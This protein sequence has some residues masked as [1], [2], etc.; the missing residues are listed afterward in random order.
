MS[1]KSRGDPVIALMVICVMMMFLALGAKLYGV[2]HA[3]T[4]WHDAYGRR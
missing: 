1:N 4:Q 2:N 3:P